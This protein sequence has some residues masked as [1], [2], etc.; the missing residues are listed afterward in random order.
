MPRRLFRSARPV[1]AMADWRDAA[2]TG[3]WSAIRWE[4]LSDSEQV[5]LLARLRAALPIRRRVDGYEAVERHDTP[6]EAAQHVAEEIARLGLTGSEAAQSR[7]NAIEGAMML[8]NLE[9]IHGAETDW[10]EQVEDYSRQLRDE[11]AQ[12]QDRPHGK[13]ALASP[14]PQADPNVARELL[15]APEMNREAHL[16]R[17]LDHVAEYRSLQRLA[18][19]ETSDADD[20]EWLLQMIH[21]AATAGYWA[22]RR[23][24]AAWGK[25]VERKASKFDKITNATRQPRPSRRQ[26]TGAKFAEALLEMERMISDS[27]RRGHRLSVAAAAERVAD[28]H[29]EPVTGEPLSGFTKRNLERR[30]LKRNK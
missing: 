13:E 8:S 27:E 18:A 15:P 7:Q 6:E 19:M 20:A 28:K 14:P 23:I 21:D 25:P 3:N 16:D 9:A 1:F 11:L 5:D 2:E 10:A 12:E 24:Q 22:G 29:R 26:A 30:Y 17:A 4:L